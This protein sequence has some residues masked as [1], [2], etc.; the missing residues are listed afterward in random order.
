MKRYLL[1]LLIT[2]AA[3]PAMAALGLGDRFSYGNLVY[4]VSNA[5]ASSPEVCVLSLTDAAKAKDFEQ[6][7]YIEIPST[8]TYSGTTYAV[9]AIESD[10]FAGQNNFQ[11]AVIN[12]GVKQVG[13][14]AFKDCKMMANIYF[15]SSIELVGNYVCQGC[16]KL[17]AVYCAM[18]EP[19]SATF[20][21][22]PFPSNT[23]MRVEVPRTNPNAI[24][25]Y[26]SLS[27]FSGFA[28]VVF[29][30]YDFKKD[31]GLSLCVT[32]APTVTTPGEVAV[33][34]VYGKT[35]IVPACG[36]GYYEHSGFKYKLTEVAEQGMSDYMVTATSKITSVDF[37]QLSYLTNIKKEAFYKC[38]KLATLKLPASLTTIGSGAFKGCSA[39]TSLNLGKN[40]SYCAYSFVDGA[41]S[42]LSI[43]M[44]PANPNMSSFNGCLY[45]KSQTRLIRWPEGK[46]TTTAWGNSFSPTI[47]TIGYYS[48]SNN[49]NLLLLRLPYGVK[50]I[51]GYAFNGCP[52]LNTVSIPS[53]VTSLAKYAFKG[54]D[55]LDWLCINMST[56]P[57]LESEFASY[58][59][60]KATLLV[61]RN[62]INAYKDA[63]GW[64]S[65]K[66]ILA[67]AYDISEDTELMYTVISNEP[68]TIDGVQYDGKAAL[69]TITSPSSTTV[70]IP[71]AVTDIYYG[72]KYAVTEIGFEDAIPVCFYDFKANSTLTLG[73]NVEIIHDCAFKEQTNLTR[74][75]LNGNLKKICYRA[76]YD[77]RIAND[78]N[79]PYGIGQVGA[80]AF[81]NN[82][83]KRIHI[84]SSIYA[85]GADMIAKCN[86]LTDIIINVP[87]MYKGTWDLTN[88]SSSCRLYVPT[89]YV[90]QYRANS[91]LG[92][93]QVSAGAYDFTYR[94]S[95]MNSTLYHI[96]ITSTSPVTVDGVTYAGKAKYV[97]HPIHKT[98]TSTSFSGALYETN[99]A[100]GVGK[101]YLM[102]EF[103]D[104]VLDG[105]KQ[106]TRVSITTMTQ[107]QRIGAWAFCLTGITGFT[108]PA[109]CTYIGKGAFSY[110]DKL[111]SLTL[112]APN[113]G[114]RTWGGQFYNN[115]AATFK[116]YVK[117]NEYKQYQDAIS[118]WTRYSSESNT[119]LERLNSYFQKNDDRGATTFSVAHPVNWNNAGGLNAYAVKSYD[120][121]KKMAITQK[122][123]ATPAGT[124][125]ILTGYANGEIYRLSR[126]STTPSTPTNLLMGNI[127]NKVD[128][129]PDQAAYAF[130]N[131]D[132]VFFRPSSNYTIE[133]GEAFLKLPTAQTSTTHIAIDLWNTKKGDVNGDGVVNVSDVTALI[134][135]ILGTATYTD[136]VCDINADG[137]VNVSDVTALI[138]MILG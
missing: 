87:N 88:I 46:T 31:D 105:C 128:I 18:P 124:G 102:T 129:R 51:E 25:L 123:T 95:D 37:S 8:V 50:S 108:V 81:Y 34:E 97:C 57:T 52:K 39:L 38:E 68:T 84:P 119:P 40:V 12:Y 79:L 3:L 132:K 76:F 65:W 104:S 103:G 101:K 61:P 114:T 64:K 2:L 69:T 21:L 14:R 24:E 16:T 36:S 17:S 90:S 67:L 44:D 131:V 133:L 55:K 96:T 28:Y 92:K 125:V 80:Q 49:K 77:C 86:Y 23:G 32:K 71:D 115:N 91:T 78:M 127:T 126:P 107:L 111:T 42:L 29:G 72:K 54:C 41:S 1:S 60:P 94:N 113:V 116:C 74:L 137:Q 56:P 112:L 83:F 35:S 138:N 13:S 7:L 85:Y 82:S 110:A 121:S 122:M 75:N 66:D 15:P 26:Q 118:N 134:N 73:K 135:K 43:D 5:S 70:T 22:T 62:K 89:G 106:I 120:A 47:E 9:T 33:T 20:G 45:N 6:L 19:T 98:L 63:S 93:L 109:S 53:S 130:S 4:Y 58:A 136:A 117:W 59:M 10:A 48:M 30:A 27:A 99:E 11:D 100:Y